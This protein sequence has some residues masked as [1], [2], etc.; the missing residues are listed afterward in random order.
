MFRTKRL[1]FAATLVAAGIASGTT[2]FAYDNHTPASKEARMVRQIRHE[3][4]MQP[5]Y[6]VFDDLSF[7]VEGNTVT[8]FG[9]VVRPS[10]KNS[11][12]QVV[13]DV[14][15]VDRVI[16]QIEVLPTSPQDD[17]IRMAVFRAIYGHPAMTRYAIQAIPPV[18]IIVKNGNVKLVG[19]VGTEQD[20]TIANIQARAVPGTF[21]VD[22]QIQVEGSSKK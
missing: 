2:A 8:L 13:K 10:M 12:E 1:A 4:I 14:E 9:A 22:N 11:S 7:R 15:G 6:G 16:N 18:H 3:L 17:R 5:F 21:Q 20:R 19:M